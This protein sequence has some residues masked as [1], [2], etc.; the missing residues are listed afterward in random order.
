[1]LYF[2]RKEKVRNRRPPVVI[3]SE[4]GTATGKDYRTTESRDVACVFARALFTKEK[5]D[6]NSTGIN[7]IKQIEF[8]PKP[9]AAPP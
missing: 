3:R 5:M 6:F 7:Y 1:M 8:D 9:I 4:G 2:L